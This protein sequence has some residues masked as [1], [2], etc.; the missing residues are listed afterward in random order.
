M[1]RYV[2]GP[3]FDGSSNKD[4]AVELCQQASKLISAVMQAVGPLRN[5]P[6][7]REISFII[8]NENSFVFAEY[9]FGLFPLFHGCYMLP[10][11]FHASV[12]Q[13][14]RWPSLVVL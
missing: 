6:Y 13:F 3:A 1:S 4:E 5:V 2:S 7:M 9:I 12:G 10:R 14:P 11:G 8:G